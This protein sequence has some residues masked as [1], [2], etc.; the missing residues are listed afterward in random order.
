MEKLYKATAEGQVE[1]TE[2]EAAEIR[3]I[4]AANELAAN[5]PKI[6]QVV[7]MRQ[8]RLAIEAAG[9]TAQ[10]DTAIAD[11]DKAAQITWEYAQE[12]HRNNPYVVGLGT[13]LGLTSEQ[14]DNLFIQ[15]AT[16]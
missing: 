3:A 12:V 5:L 2:E 13:A 8:A 4:W 11:L 1:M 14:I 15:A 16:L 7:T 9:L 10:L 6:P